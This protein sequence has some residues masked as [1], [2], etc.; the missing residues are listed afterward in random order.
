MGEVFTPEELG[1]M[2]SAGFS[3]DEVNQARQES[4][5]EM[6]HAGFKDDEIQKYYNLKEPDFS[7]ATAHVKRS[8]TT[9][10]AA[11]AELKTGPQK[12]EPIDASV[13][14]VEAK[15]L[16]D[17]LAAG[18]GTSVT[19]LFARGE[20]SP[21]TTDHA[22]RAI[23]IASMIAQFAG[24]IPAMAA[25]MTAGAAAGGT[26]GS[27]ALPVVGT[28]SG[29]AVGGMA[30]AFAVPPAMRRM[31]MDQYEKGD[32]K[33]AS[34]AADRFVAASWEGIKGGVTGTATSIVGGPAG[35]YLGTIGK[36]TAEA[37][38]MSTV[39]AG[40]EGHLPDPDDFVNAMVMMGGFHAI[41]NVGKLRGIYSRTGLK[42]E[43][44]AEMA[45]TNPALKQEIMS[46]GDEFP[47]SLEPLL[48]EQKAQEPKAKALE[49]I[50][51]KIQ[52]QMDPVKRSYGFDEF[53]K[54]YVDKYDPIAKLEDKTFKVD[55]VKENT[56]Q[57]GYKLMRM[58]S[59]Y[60]AKAKVTIEKGTL[61]YNDLSING[62]SLKKV[63]APVKENLQDFERFAVAKR[64]LELESRGIESGFD[65]ADAKAVVKGL[66][67][68]MGDAFRNFVDFQ[69]RNMKYLRD[70]GRIDNKQYEKLVDLG[71]SYVSFKRVFEP[72]DLTGTRGAG[73][74]NPLKTIEGS[75]LA[76]QRPITSAI[77]N[78]EF[79]FKWAESNRA[80]VQLVENAEKS[81]NEAYFEKVKSNQ[82][83]KIDASGEANELLADLGV[84]FKLKKGEFDVFRSRQKDLAPNEFEIWRGGKREIYR[85]KDQNVADSLAALD[86][87]PA[88][89]NLFM[90]IMRKF[91]G[92]KRFATTTTV[93]FQ[94]KNLFR[95]QLTA[96]SLSEYSTIPF[97]EVVVAMGDL[98][99]ENDHYY[100]WLKSGGADGAFMDLGESYLKTDIYGI[101]KKTGFLG[102]IQ[103]SVKATARG[104]T[105]AGRII[106]SSSRL[107]EFKRAT[108]MG[109]EG[110]ETRYAESGP[111]I[112]EGGFASREITVDF[113]RMGLKTQ[114]FNSIAAFFNAQVQGVDR[115]ARALG[116]DWRSLKAGE[117]EDVMK[118]TTVRAAALL[119]A[120]S[121]A[122]WAI[123]RSDPQLAPWV[124]EV[125][126]WEQDTF[127]CIPIPW[128]RAAESDDEWR[129]L[130]DYKVQDSPQGKLI[131]KGVILRLPKPQ[132]LGLL[133]AT[134]PVRILEKY[135]DEKPEA[136]AGILDTLQGILVPNWKPDLLAPMGEQMT[137]Y[138]SFTGRPLVPQY[139]EKELPA[140]RYTE[141]TSATAKTLGKLLGAIPYVQ[142]RDGASPMVIDNY[143]KSWTGTLGQYAVDTLDLAL[144]KSG[145]ADD[146]QPEMSPNDIWFVKSFLVRN[147]TTQSESIQ[148]FYDRAK[149][150]DQI[151]T[152]TKNQMKLGREEDVEYIEKHFGQVSMRI[153]GFKNALSAQNKII[154]GVYNSDFTKHEKRQL[155][156]STYWQMIETAKFAN[157]QID[158]YEKMLKNSNQ[159][160]EQ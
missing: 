146:N 156:E 38:T 10:K 160:A 155:I 116:K 145:V 18:W 67:G 61:S 60:K 108:E 93:D 17:G 25:G 123:T 86:G 54:D 138:N 129:D 77:E 95:D 127:W 153:E 73:K 107:A 132:E 26:L 15:D 137:N 68:E 35:A 102:G 135:V 121:I 63:L 112:F 111:K 149:S 21:L 39:A 82:L 157:S 97:R 53:Y 89:Q 142:E 100:N 101:D 12:R 69:N 16:L 134:L 41:G 115:T 140:Y 109:R 62:D 98:W 13:Q 78:A 37:L 22:S 87:Q 3:P 33:S 125:P 23:K 139:I 55:S 126:K 47:K 150:L 90:R 9:S 30:G 50:G 131:N 44:V 57:S 76:V 152:S 79:I 46:S 11:E 141:Y 124:A 27:V 31:L 96:G 20:K 151:L 66:K 5:V 144:R 91:T 34:D 65:I 133:F 36:L 8:I 120:P 143:I 94:A 118:G 64:A 75:D 14:P 71:K 128:W 49:N 117:Y 43:E 1:T 72:E 81:G 40:L 7:E 83:L 154:R 92:L 159:G 110:I 45:E 80:K 84:D 52:D 148:R 42:P 48:D 114:S 119:T 105:L 58:A 2:P 59:D 6:A 147:P 32:V 29:A 24:D 74:A 28:V 88:M 4:M 85:V 19:G 122:L 106:E 103:N 130:P 99:K 51:A 158:R 70:A 104:M 113:Q 56:A 136:M